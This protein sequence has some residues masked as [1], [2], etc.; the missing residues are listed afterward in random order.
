MRVLFVCSFIEW[1]LSLEKLKYFECSMSPGLSLSATYVSSFI[2][3]YLWPPLSILFLNLFFKHFYY[4]IKN[5]ML[6]VA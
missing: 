4:F 3:K 6:H 1:P 5:T 2:L